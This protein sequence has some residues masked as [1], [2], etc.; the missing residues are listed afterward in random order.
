MRD[1]SVITGENEFTVVYNGNPS[2][3]GPILLSL[4]I[5]TGKKT[6]QFYTDGH[7]YPADKDM[8]ERYG[9]A[10]VTPSRCGRR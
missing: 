10:S 8:I 1:M 4:P 2:A 7:G 9:S 6:M 3:M 5:R